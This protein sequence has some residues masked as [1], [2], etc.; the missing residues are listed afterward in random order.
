[1]RGLLFALM[2]LSAAPTGAWAQWANPPSPDPPEAYTHRYRGFLY[3][4]RVEPDEVW[5]TCNWLFEQY[6]DAGGART[7]H[8]PD[9]LMGCS[10]TKPSTFGQAFSECR[11]VVPRG[12]EET[13]IHEIAHCNGW[14]SD[15]PVY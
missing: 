8:S 2:V 4:Y 15:H 5:K 3:V 1:M 6:P 12:D 11:I 7:L 9:E 10:V 14:P 13:F